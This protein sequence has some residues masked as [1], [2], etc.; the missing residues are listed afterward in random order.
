MAKV[1]PTAAELEILTLLWDSGP[2]SVREVHRQL[3]RHRDV[4]YTTTLKTMQVMTDKGLLERDTSQRAHIYSPAVSRDGIEKNLID[5][6][7]KSMFNGSTAGL[8]ISALG[9]SKPTAEELREIRDMIDKMDKD[10]N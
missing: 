3:S 6:L 8:I 10:D 1:K 7:R 9:H 2:S 4:F 5:T